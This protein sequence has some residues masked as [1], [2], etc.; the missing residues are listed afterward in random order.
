MKRRTM[1]ARINS[2]TQP[3]TRPRAGL[4]VTVTR[5]VA[6]ITHRQDGLPSNRRREIAKS[7]PAKIYRD[8]EHGTD[9]DEFTGSKH[10]TASSGG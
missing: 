8:G 2:A 7:V 4:T 5:A 10:G 6:P 9:G 1:V 3:N